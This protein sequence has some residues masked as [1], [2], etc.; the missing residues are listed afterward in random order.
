MIDILMLVCAA[1]PAVSFSWNFFLFRK[2]GGRSA[3]AA[4]SVLIPARNEAAG[5][6]AAVGSVLRNRDV[7]FE[8]LV[9]NDHSE[10]DTAAVVKSLSERDSRVRL[11]SAP[12]LPAGWNGK[13]HACHVLA[14]HARYDLLCFVDADVRLR[15]DALS[16]M[17]AL[18]EGSRSSL[19]SGFPRQ[20]TETLLERLLIPL[21]HFVLLGY[22]PFIFVRLTKHPAFAAGCGQLML[23][24][25]EAYRRTE[26]HAAIRSSMHDGIRLPALFRRSGE[27]TGVFDATDLATCRMYRNA[28]EVWKGL[29][30][31]AVEGMAA[32]GRIVVFTTLL[33]AGQVLPFVLLPFSQAAAIAVGL[34]LAQRLVSVIRFRQ[35]VDSAILHPLGVLL[36]LIIQWYALVRHLLGR[37]AVWKGRSCPPE[38]TEPSRDSADSSV[39]T[40]E[41]RC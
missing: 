11:L 35:P 19:M 3:R 26:G 31:N 21:I 10:D 17:A 6:A 1:I 29:A 25:A 28:G 36:L 37:P 13:Q 40:P 16:R 15:P 14:Q 7:E 23:A 32:P 24:R 38:F 34:A 27:H 20:E 8:V 41:P 18:F 30:K 9:L 5:I 2:P 33:L 39:P 4:V 12:P 22:L